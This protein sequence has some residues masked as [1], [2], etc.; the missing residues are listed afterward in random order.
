MLLFQFITKIQ[1]NFNCQTIIRCYNHGSPHYKSTSCNLREWIN[2]HIILCTTKWYDL[3]LTWPK[4]KIFRAIKCPSL[5][6]FSYCNQ[7]EY[8]SICLWGILIS[9]S[10]P[11]PFIFSLSIHLFKDYF[12]KD[13]LALEAR[14][15]LKTCLNAFHA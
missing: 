9:H 5:K 2:H 14:A 13:F 10:H 3:P 7:N 1:F 6:K 12:S 11:Y 15:S 8:F 4:N